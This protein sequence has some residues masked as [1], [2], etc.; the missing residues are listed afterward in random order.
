[1]TRTGASAEQVIEALAARAHG[2]VTRAQLI[3]AGVSPDVID[4]RLAAKRLHALHRGV[5]RV[6]PLIAAR[7]AELAAVLACGDD[8]V[9]SHRTAA[10]LWRLPPEP[11]AGSPPEVI[12]PRQLRRRRPGVRTHRLALRA[13][14]ITAVD[15]IPVTTP[16]RTLYDLAGTTPLRDLERALAESL[17]RGLT[18]R[19]RLEAVLVRNAHR[20][21]TPRLRALLAPDRP[22][23]RTRSEAEAT[24]LDLIT[25]AQL[26]RPEVNVRVRGYEVDFLWRRRRLVAEIDGFAFHASRGRFEADRRRDIELTAAGLRVIRVTWRQLEG[27]PEALAA[28][29][30]QALAVA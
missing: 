25:R 20:V 21:G 10:A 13:D 12:I 19:A 26:D 24:F 5:Y 30:A 6:G 1:M 16:S 22:P 29:V 4:R 23:A 11:A 15:G 3:A 17:A 9:A 2:V 27:E 14:E 8:A 18:T 7:A 28:R